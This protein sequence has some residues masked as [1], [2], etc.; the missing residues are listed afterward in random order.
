MKR[1]ALVVA[2]ISAALVFTPVEPVYADGD[3]FVG[4]LI[5]GIIGG[6]IAHEAGK[7]KKRSTGAPRASTKKAT[8]ARPSISS[9]QREANREV[10][11]ALNQ[12]GF[13]VGTPD[14]AIGPKSRAAISQYQAL[15]GYPATGQLTEYE[16]T[17][18]V[19]A[20]HRSVAGGPAV[21]QA[22]ASHPMGMRGL[23]LIQRD[24]MAGIVPQQ[25]GAGV[26]AATAGVMAAAPALAPEPA[27]QLPVLAAAPEPAA[28][29]TPVLP[30]FG[31]AAVVSLASHCNQVGLST[32]AAGGM[33]TLAT[34]TDANV[35]LAEQF[36]LTRAHV[37]AEGEGLARNVPGFTPQQI[38]EQCKAFGP[39]LKEH[40]A[41][42]SVRPAAEVMEGVAGFVPASGMAPAQLT[43]T[44]R[45]CLGVGYAADD[46]DVAIGAALLLTTLGETGYSE[47]LGHHLSQ[48]FGASRRADLALDWYEQATGGN[49]G[50]IVP[51]MP[52]RGALIQKA[53]YAINGRVEAPAAPALPVLAPA[54]APAPEVVVEAPVI[55]APVIEAPV[56]EAPVVA[57]PE[58]VVAVQPEVTPA[59]SAPEP[60]VQAVADVPAAA[61]SAGQGGTVRAV[62]M[63]ARL[64]GLV[65]GN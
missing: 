45:I 38:A 28:P 58:V 31:S 52:D 33:V 11:T 9:A 42:L 59:P 1:K 32:S 63:L 60:V 15:L 20:Y 65:F 35:A 12:F 46:M 50:G 49:G 36:C 34:M 6:A 18:L 7:K 44:A 26:A 10:Q 19:T 16:R 2:G 30:S 51:G 48:G 39:V 13:P 27:P 14:G 8:P 62:S 5:G 24:E 25:G 4:G 21:M 53:A 47:L 29:A 43:A 37:M 17:L 23:L 40:V 57:T 54:P 56:I 41:A 22:A 3:A 55:E 64:P 61:P